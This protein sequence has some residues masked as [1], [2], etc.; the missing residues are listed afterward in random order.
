ML[1]NQWADERRDE[2]I[3]FKVSGANKETLRRLARARGLSLSDLIRSFVLA[4]IEQIL[5]EAEEV[6][7]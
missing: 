2:Q 3:R 1:G 7:Q 5:A 6:K 4:G